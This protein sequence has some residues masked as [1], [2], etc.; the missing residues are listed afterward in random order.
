MISQGKI[1]QGVSMGHHQCEKCCWWL[2]NVRSASQPNTPL[3]SR[4]LLKPRTLEALL[5]NEYFCWRNDW[6][7]PQ[8]CMNSLCQSCWWPWIQV[9]VTLCTLDFSIFVAWWFAVWEFD[10]RIECFPQKKVHINTN[11]CPLSV[12]SLVK[13]LCSGDLDHSPAMVASQNLEKW[14]FVNTLVQ[15]TKEAWESVVSC[16]FYHQDHPLPRAGLFPAPCFLCHVCQRVYCISWGRSLPIFKGSFLQCSLGCDVLLYNYQNLASPVTSWLAECLTS[17]VLG[18]ATL[19][20]TQGL[21]FLKGSK[22]VL[23]HL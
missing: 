3:L 15:S 4:C 20:Q 1:L 23:F 17:T 11:A 13:N 5:S 10:E 14:F 22:I 9:W 6:R 7:V 19:S 16:S 2:A 21:S 8:L 18:W 12:D